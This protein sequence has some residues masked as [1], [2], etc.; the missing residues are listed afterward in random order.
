[1]K[2]TIIIPT[3]RYGKFDITFSGLGKQTFNDNDW[4]IIIIDDFIEN[5]RNECMDVAKKYNVK[6]VLYLRPKQ[7]YWRSNNSIANSRNTGLIRAKGELIIFSD[8]YVW[9]PPK[10]VE[11]HWKMYKEGKYTLIGGGCATKYM[12][13]KIDDINR[14]PLPDNKDDI[15]NAT[16]RVGVH[17]KHFPVF[18]DTRTPN[19]V[20]NCG[21]GWLYRFNASAP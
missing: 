21:G 4:E 6:N 18:M 10:F 14:L 7:Q 16:I 15:E 8:D 11:E 19:N 2:V 20:K 12:P 17:Y 13:E 5:R 3:N 9:F 1:M